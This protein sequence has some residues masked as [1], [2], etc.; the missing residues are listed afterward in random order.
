M[1]IL[2]IFLLLAA[3]TTVGFFTAAL[4]GAASKGE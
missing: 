3:G 4:M 2:A 1:S